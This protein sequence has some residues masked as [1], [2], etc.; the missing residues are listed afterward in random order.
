MQK[1]AASKAFNDYIKQNVATLHVVSG[2]E[3]TKFLETQE[4]LYK[5][6]LEAPRGST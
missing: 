1:V 4:A 5:D 3:F 6:M 2:P